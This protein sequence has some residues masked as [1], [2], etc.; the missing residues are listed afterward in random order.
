M[1][2]LDGLRSLFQPKGVFD[3]KSGNWTL[4]RDWWSCTSTYEWKT[5]IWLFHFVFIHLFIFVSQHF[6][7]SSHFPIFLLHSPSVACSAS[8]SLSLSF[9]LKIFLS[10]LFDTHF[11]FI[12]FLFASL[13]ISMLL[14]LS[15][16]TWSWS[17]WGEMMSWT[18]NPPKT[19]VKAMRSQGEHSPVQPLNIKV[20]C[21][22]TIFCLQIS[23][24]VSVGGPVKY[25]KQ[26]HN[27]RRCN[28]EFQQPLGGRSHS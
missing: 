23:L 27:L 22:G 24:V 9:L 18:Q 15:T 26:L 20:L 6:I 7:L 16:K 8:P 2:G 17:C 13:H 21:S 28:P 12:P 14:L 19:T 1:V 25:K 11:S 10:I 5:W 4:T 3:S